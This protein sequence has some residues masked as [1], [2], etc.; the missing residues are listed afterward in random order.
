MSNGSNYLTA[1]EAGIPEIEQIKIALELIL[2]QGGIAVIQQIY[3][4]VEGR[5]GNNNYLSEQGKHSLRRTINTSAVN[6][7][8]IYP[9]DDDNQGWRITDAGVN[10]IRQELGQY[11][12]NVRITS[13]AY[14][15][16]LLALKEIRTLLDFYNDTRQSASRRSSSLEIFKKTGIILI[17]T[18]W[19]TFIEDI[20][21]LYIDQRLNN[22]LSPVE[23]QEA[24][25][26][27]AQNWYA[28]IINKQANRP[29]D[30]DFIK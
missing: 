25:D 1:A 24:F 6:R 9:Y 27:V 14:V 20:F 17:V 18:S 4:A 21:K 10:F 19:E 3:D 5:M 15:N 23:M 2:A 8:Y 28:A 29:T 22:A 13:R 11:I 26:T 30:S 7:G 12:G 16:F